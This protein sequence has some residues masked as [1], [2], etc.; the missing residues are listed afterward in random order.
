MKGLPGVLLKMW[1]VSNGNMATPTSPSAIKTAYLNLR[2]FP[3][4]KLR[5]KL[6]DQFVATVL[7]ENPVGE[8]HL[9][10]EHLIQE[11]RRWMP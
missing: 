8:N 6:G 9:D 1:V 11:V 3:G 5:S 2:T 7:L 4:S 10:Y